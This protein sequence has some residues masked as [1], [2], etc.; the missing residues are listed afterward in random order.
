[1]TQ[2]TWHTCLLDLQQ[3][4]AIM[5]DWLATTVAAIG[6]TPGS[7]WTKKVPEGFRFWL[8]PTFQASQHGREFIA[9]WHAVP[10]DKP[11]PLP[12][13]DLLGLIMSCGENGDWELYGI[14]RP[15]SRF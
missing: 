15:H 9:R 6:Q 8:S 10:S 7:I 12:E 5:D 14:P 11:N 2:P 3:H 1:M 4:Q 13:H